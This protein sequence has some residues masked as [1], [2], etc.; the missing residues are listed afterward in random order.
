MMQ[1]LSRA[2]DTRKRLRPKDVQ[3]LEYLMMQ[4]GRRRLR[5]LLQP[6]RLLTH[7]QLAVGRGRRI[8]GR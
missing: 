5:R 7:N 1:S 8:Q 4:L 3:L 6:V 2:A